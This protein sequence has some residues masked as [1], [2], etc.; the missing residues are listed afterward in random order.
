MATKLHTLYVNI[1][2]LF[3]FPLISFSQTTI[4]E[5]NFSYPNGTTFGTGN[6]W[7]TT[8]NTSNGTPENF[9]VINN[10]F[11]AAFLKSEQQVFET[12]NIDISSY[13]NVS[14][15]IDLDRANGAQFDDPQDYIRVYYNL[16][17][18]TETQFSY[19]TGNFVHPLVGSITGLNGSTL[20][21]IIKMFNS[22]D[23][24]VFYFDNI[25]VEGTL[26]ASEPEIDV[27]GNG[28]AIPNNDISPDILDD[29]DYG[30]QNISISKNRTFTIQNTGTSNLTIADI[31]ISGTVFTITGTP[32]NSPVVAGGTTTFTVTGTPSSIGA[33]TETV[34]IT[35]NDS[36]ESSYQFDVKITGE[37]AF[38]DSD[39]D[40][41]FDNIDIDDDND[42]IRD[43]YEE[44]SCRNS[45]L[46]GVASYKYLYETFGTLNPGERHTIPS[47][48]Y[49]FE[50]GIPGTTCGDPNW[51]LDDGEYCVVSKITGI[52][53]GDPQNIHG[54]L[55]WTNSLDHTPSDGNTGGM[56]VFNAE[57]DPGVFYE[58]TI[59]GILPNVPI[60]Y[61]FWVLNIMAQSKFPGSILPNVTVQ[62]VDLAGNELVPP[63]DTEEFGR[64]AA[65]ITDNSCSQG[66]WQQ[67]TTNVNLGNVNE[68][69]VRFINN[70]PGGSGN[71]LALDDIEISQ[72]LCDLDNDGVADV[73]DLDSDNDGIPDVVEAGLGNLSAGTA[74]ISYASGWLDTNGNG[75]HDLAE[76]NTP[77]DTDGDGVPN[78]LDLDSDNDSIFDVDE[79]GAG[80]TGN[81]NLQNGDGDINGDGVGDG[82]DTDAVRETDFDSNDS[83]EYFTDGILDI[84]D[85]FN[86]TTFATAYGNSNQGSTGLGWYYYVLDTDNDGIPDYMDVT[87]NVTF[88]IIGT[89]Y[90]S[91]DTNN[92]G[93]IDGITDTDGDGILDLFDTDNTAFGSPRDLNRKLHL[94]FDGRNDYGEDTNVISSGDATLMA[95][96]KSDGDNTN[97]DTSNFA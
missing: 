37:E 62:F 68:F 73:F 85:Y 66:D 58:T 54:D 97:G 84:Y 13:S 88:D 5:E 25:L 71:D 78:Y 43:A 8:V 95:F 56:A 87:S 34:T 91:L 49:C 23:I 15:S 36:D 26:V 92:D 19:S 31:L 14:I 63:I 20:K 94:Y 38:F 76:S 61:S 10:R 40:G 50:D 90:A 41:V 93:T 47:T 33:F 2:L 17:G 59:T 72:T 39:G 35:N 89:L 69:I 80:N 21:I 44:L 3:I 12:E 4:W 45:S 83:L 28:L 9:N 81:P 18:G 22:E 51:I 65:S 24:E 67:F 79:S 27:F 96:I 70:A 29:T 46:A 42:G 53:A 82:L 57:W 11:E 74:K 60:T 7:I 55:A 75:M 52:T 64:C 16:N 48:N 6:R 77:L 32:F 86:G 1:F 30:T